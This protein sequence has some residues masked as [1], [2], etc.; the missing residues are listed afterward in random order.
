MQKVTAREESKDLAKD[1]G[2]VLIYA[3]YPVTGK[4]FLRVKYGLEEAPE[5]APTVSSHPEPASASQAPEP[6]PAT[7]SS[8]ARS[9]NVYLSGRSFQVTVDPADGGSLPAA[10][11]QVAPNPPQP[12]AQPAPQVQAI[13]T[14]A[15]APAPSAPTAEVSAGEVGLEAPMPGIVLRYLVGEG[16][17]VKAGDSIVILEAMKMENALPSP[18]NGVVKKISVSNGSRVSRGDVLAV[19]SPS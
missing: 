10:T 15:P 6:Q 3:L 1:I 11:A 7:V 12:V 13:A 8:N 18:S 19:I 9:F 17:S 5:E 14:P 2:D 16:D 4:R